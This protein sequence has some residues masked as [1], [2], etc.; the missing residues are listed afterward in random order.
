MF[1]L[2]LSFDVSV[3]KQKYCHSFMFNKSAGFLRV[4]F[5]GGVSWKRLAE[6][7]GTERGNFEEGGTKAA[8]GWEPE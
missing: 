2:T 3:R 4:S 1:S 7:D 5:D 6:V 8:R